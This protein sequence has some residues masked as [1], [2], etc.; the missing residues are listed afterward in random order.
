MLKQFKTTRIAQFVMFAAIVVVIASCDSG[1]N[2]DKFVAGNN[3]FEDEISDITGSAVF[4]NTN[5]TPKNCENLL[6][7]YTRYIDKLVDWKVCADEIGQ[8]DQLQQ[9]INDAEASKSNLDCG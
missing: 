2:C 5:P 7:A 3:I 6:A 8:G 1:V 9:F 4:Y